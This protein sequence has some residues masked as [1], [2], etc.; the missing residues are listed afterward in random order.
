MGNNRSGKVLN[1]GA[2][3][4]SQHLA[5]CGIF[6]GI[7]QDGIFAADKQQAL[8]LAHIDDLQGKPFQGR[9]GRGRCC[10]WGKFLPQEK[11]RQCQQQE[12]G[13]P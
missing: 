11:G 4:G 1:P 10:R 6:A 2:G 13:A 8:C 3:K 7:N 9:V 5:A 12:K